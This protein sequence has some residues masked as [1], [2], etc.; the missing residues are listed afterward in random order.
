[1]EVMEADVAEVDTYMIEQESNACFV[2]CRWT[3]RPRDTRQSIKEASIIS[4]LRTARPRLT[5]IHRDTCEC[6]ES[7]TSCYFTNL[8]PLDSSLYPSIGRDRQCSSR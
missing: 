4:V 6:L 7:S 5:K 8:S 1:M 2:E 3:R